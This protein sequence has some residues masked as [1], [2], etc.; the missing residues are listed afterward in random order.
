MR[1]KN[2]DLTLAKVEGVFERYCESLRKRWKTQLTRTKKTG[3]LEVTSTGETTRDGQDVTSESEQP[4][5]RIKKEKKKVR[6]ELVDSPGLT[7]QSSDTDE[8]Q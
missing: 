6:F 3:I 8:N 5:E 2:N 4:I 1:D 7:N